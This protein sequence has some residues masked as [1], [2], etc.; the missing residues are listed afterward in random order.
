MKKLFALLFVGI[1]SI[2]ACSA[3]APEVK[4]RILMDVYPPYNYVDE[5]GQV[6][7]R[8]TEMVQAIEDKLGLKTKI[9]V[10]PWEQAF[11]LAQKEPGVALFSASRSPERENMF[12]WVGPLHNYEKHLYARKG[13]GIKINSLA[14]IRNAK[15]ISVVKNES[16]EKICLDAGGKLIYSV[17]DYESLKKMMDGSADLWLGPGQDISLVAKEAGVNPDD[18]ESVF[19]VHK[20][21]MFIAFNKNTPPAI[22]QQWQ[23]ALDSIKK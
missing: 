15:A 20:Y 16:G 6:A 8:S 12:L 19:V 14:D 9:E 21:G 13:S 1:F 17:T 23:Q 3:P 22:V 5:N 10:M 7:G 2:L 11:E 18:I 4:V